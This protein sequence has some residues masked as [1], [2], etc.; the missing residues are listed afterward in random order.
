[1]RVSAISAENAGGI[2]GA[3]ES[4]VSDAVKARN[5]KHALKWAEKNFGYD[6]RTLEKESGGGYKEP[7]T[8]DGP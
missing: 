4:S 2:R 5:D 1:M 3:F 7:A 8:V 6:P